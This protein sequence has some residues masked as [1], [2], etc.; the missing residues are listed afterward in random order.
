MKAAQSSARISGSSSKARRQSK[1]AKPLLTSVSARGGGALQRP[2]ARAVFGPAAALERRLRQALR[3]GLACGRGEAL[4]HLLRVPGSPRPGRRRR[5]RV[6]VQLVPEA[7]YR[8]LGIEG[9]VEA[10]RRSRQGSAAPASRVSLRRSSS[11]PAVR[12]QLGAEHELRRG[13]VHLPRKTPLKGLRDPRAPKSGS[14]AGRAPRTVC[15]PPPPSRAPA[16]VAHDAKLH[17]QRARRRRGGRSPGSPGYLA[18]L[19][20]VPTMLSRTRQRS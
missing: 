5:R 18:M 14:G 15:V 11:P 9:G 12:R 17:V 4:E 8:A 13:D 7:A 16:H 10:G 19:S 6:P 2:D 1:P 20:T 3:C